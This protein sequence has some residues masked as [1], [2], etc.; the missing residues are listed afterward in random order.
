MQTAQRFEI[1]ELVGSGGMGMVYRARDRSTGQA[2]ALKLLPRGADSA[3]FSLE[4]DVLARLHHPGVVGFAGHG[5]TE[6][7]QH[8]LAMQWLEGETLAARLKRGPLGVTETRLLGIG[9]ADALEAAHAAGIV[10]RDVKPSNLFIVGADPARVSLIDFGIAALSAAATR[11]TT[12]GVIMGTAAYM[13]PEQ[14]RGSGDVDGRCDLFSLGSVLYRCLAGRSP[15]DGDDV[16]VILAKLMF[17]EPPPLPAHVPPGLASLV[18]ELL[19]K[20]PA[21]RPASAT[22]V[23]ARLRRLAVESPAGST[24]LVSAADSGP[25]ISSAE[26]ELVSVVLVEPLRTPLDDDIDSSDQRVS[27]VPDAALASCLPAL[28]STASAFGA[29]LELL[30]DGSLLAVLRGSE[31]AADLSHRAARCALGLRG[32]LPAQN[33]LAVATGRGLVRDRVLVGE[34]VERAARLLAKQGAPGAIRLDEVSAGLLDAS[35]ALSTA[36]RHWQLHEH[37][38]EAVTLRTMLGRETRCVGRSREIG[39]LLGVYEESVAERAPRVALLTG[40]AGLGK[41]RIRHELL[42]ALARHDARPLVLTAKGDSV[43]GDSAFRLI[44][45]LTRDAGSPRWRCAEGRPHELAKLVEPSSDEPSGPSSAWQ[46]PQAHTQ[47]IHRALEELFE[48]ECAR[49]PVVL[50]LDDLQW[51]D[52]ASIECIDACLRTL[53]ASAISVLAF[54]RPDL[55]ERFP[56][57]WSRRGLLELRLRPLSAR[58]QQEL[59]S[60]ILGASADPSSV[61][62]LI[63]LAGGNPFYLEELV[64][65]LSAGQSDR[66]PETLLSMAHSRL[67][68]L[69]ELDRRALRA[70]S[71]FGGALWPDAVARLLGVEDAATIAAE[72]ERLCRDEVLQRDPES[73]YPQSRQYS[74]RQTLLREAAYHALTDDDR[75]LGHRLAAAWLERVG[76]RD[77][78]VLAHHL[79]AGGEHEQARRCFVRAAWAAYRAGDPRATRH[80]ADCAEAE[81]A[82]GGLLGEVFFLRGAA[83][84]WKGELEPSLELHERALVLLRHNHDLWRAAALRVAAAAAALGHRSRFIELAELLASGPVT[85]D[86]P[87]SIAVVALLGGL[88]LQSGDVELANRCFSHIDSVDVAKVGAQDPDTAV[89]ILD[90]RARR[91]GAAGDLG[92]QLENAELA[93]SRYEE[94]TAATRSCYMRTVA[95]NAA[96]QLGAWKRASEH[97]QRA[98]ATARRNALENAEAV[99]RANLGVVVTRMGDAEAGLAQ[100]GTAIDL[101]ARQGDRRGEGG[102]RAYRAGI[103]LELGQIRDARAEAEQADE[104]LRAA[105]PMRP[106][107]LAMRSRALL[108]MGKVAAATECAEEAW[109]IAEAQHGAEAEGWASAALALTSAYAASGDREAATELARVA[110]RQIEARAARIRDPELRHGFVHDVPE[111]TALTAE[112]AALGG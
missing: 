16:R 42:D 85:P 100:L 77:P 5:V 36:D 62:R 18:F 103:Q 72:L 67:A 12:T 45:E 50:V 31:N 106:L 68:A 71:V 75:Q 73:R 101:F 13:A 78:I 22:V 47:R 38:G 53:E 37:R 8:Y 26:Q 58:A 64:R 35:F 86:D 4:A 84:R 30:A 1:L 2:V 34:V 60:E 56:A 107:A 6:E 57:L 92:G 99:C 102:A 74:F 24:T 88:C 104:L 82:E 95:A 59:L 54:G 19:R 15:F 70:A 32:E 7:G 21:D 87:P 10:H 17:D 65:A 48:A 96:M 14:A 91:A 43:R 46:D 76:E 81:G 41:S 112:L 29:T 90:A 3:R 49:H 28:R 109:T 93:L 83:A 44:L 23:A 63:A 27:L 97:L 11:L 55:H 89:R 52:Q 79:A 105:P 80:F 108:A 110:V 69:P 39:A 33:V 25:S 61:E 66:L 40:A 51:G 20:E 111:H 98:I 9:V 94:A